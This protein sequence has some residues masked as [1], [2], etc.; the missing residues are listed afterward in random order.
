MDRLSPMIQ[1]SSMAVIVRLI[2]DEAG[3]CCLLCVI[4]CAAGMGRRMIETCFLC[5]SLG[6]NWYPQIHSFE[7]VCFKIEF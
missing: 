1:P 4:S 5:R 6:H 3:F 2:L 7:I